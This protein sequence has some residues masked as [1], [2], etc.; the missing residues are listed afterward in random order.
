MPARKTTG[1]IEPAVHVTHA[2]LRL[3]AAL[4]KITAELPTGWAVRVEYTQQG[5][6]VHLY[7]PTGEAVPVKFAHRDLANQIREAVNFSRLRNRK[8]K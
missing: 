2:S 4:E 1:S 6:E 5:A 3:A 8:G 7:D